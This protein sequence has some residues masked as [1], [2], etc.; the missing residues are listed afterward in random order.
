[1]ENV[2]ASH[3]YVV[4]DKHDQKRDIHKKRKGVHYNMR[5]YPREG[6]E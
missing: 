4:Q 3:T 2:R 6:N 5:H 1:M